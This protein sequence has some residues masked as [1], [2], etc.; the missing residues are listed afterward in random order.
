MIVF[1]SVAFQCRGICSWYLFPLPLN[2]FRMLPKWCFNQLYFLKL[3]NG[4]IWEISPL[5][6][7]CKTVFFML[8]QFL[9][10]F[11]TSSLILTSTSRCRITRESMQAKSAEICFAIS[12]KILQSYQLTKVLDETIVVCIIVGN[13]KQINMAFVHFL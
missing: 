11:F 8:F 6:S 12:I 4:I 3:D 9:F 2:C 1:H 7:K 13:E 5:G 10:H